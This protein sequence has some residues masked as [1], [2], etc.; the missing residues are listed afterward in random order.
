MLPPSRGYQWVFVAVTKHRGLRRDIA[1]VRHVRRG[2]HDF[3]SWF[4]QNFSVYAIGL[5]MDRPEI[6]GRHEEIIAVLPESHSL[7]VP[8]TDLVSVAKK[9]SSRRRRL[10]YLT[11]KF[12]W[13]L[14][15]H[16]VLRRY[17]QNRE[18]RSRR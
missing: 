3:V 2:T 8:L 17:A 16:R 10:G 9:A 12:M 5:P 4:Y 11:R 18:A 6:W 13:E 14:Y 7:I 1:P 15:G